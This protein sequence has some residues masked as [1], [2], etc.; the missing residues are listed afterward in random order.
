MFYLAYI[1]FFYSGSRLLLLFEGCIG[2]DKMICFAFYIR[3]NV[4]LT[5]VKFM[6]KR[7]CG[8]RKPHAFVSL[9]SFNQFE[10]KAL[11]SDF[12]NSPGGSVGHIKLLCRPI[13]AS[14]CI[15]GRK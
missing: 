12:D 5:V 2:K 8:L 4:F 15:Y 1:R 14:A 3:F 9:G 13:E 6:E 7:F 10:A 11:F